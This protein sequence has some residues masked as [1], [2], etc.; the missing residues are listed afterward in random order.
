MSL[1]EEGAALFED[2]AALVEDGAALVVDSPSS[3]LSLSSSLPSSSPCAEVDSAA[4]DD[5]V[6]EAIA[7]GGSVTGALVAAAT[8]VVSSRILRILLAAPS[9][10]LNKPCLRPW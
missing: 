7:G 3:S 9:T 1:V 2:N 5:C 10:S 4:C 6:A 8:N